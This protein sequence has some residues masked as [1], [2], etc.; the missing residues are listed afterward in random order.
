MKK[1]KQKPEQKIKKTVT[2]SVKSIPES[3]GIDGSL[4]ETLHTAVSIACN[5]H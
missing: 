4:T 1:L 5:D 2:V 3:N